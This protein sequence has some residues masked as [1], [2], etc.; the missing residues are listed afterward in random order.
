MAKTSSQKSSKRKP[1]DVINCAQI[2]DYME[3]VESGEVRA[4]ERQKKLCKHIRHVFATEELTIDYERIDNYGK[5]LRFFPFDRLF[6]WEWFVLT[7]FLCV[8]K[9]NGEP[10]WDELYCIVGRGAGKNGL[11][12]FMAFCLVAAANGIRH[13]NVNIVANSEEQAKTSFEDVRRVLNGAQK[14][15]KPKFDWNKTEIVCKST[16]SEIKY[17]TSGASSKDGGRP[18]LVVFD[19]VHEFTSWKLI[20]VLTTG[21]GKVDH[22]RTAIISSN[23][24]VRGGVF[25]TILESC[26][27]ILNGEE[28]DNGILP[29]VCTLDN[30][31]EVHDEANWEKANP[32]FRYLPER[33]KNRTRKEYRKWVK[34][35]AGGNAS[36]MTRRMGIPQ[37][38][39]EHEIATWENLTRCMRP[40][41]DLDGQPCVLGLDVSRKDD[42]FSAVLLF[43]DGNGGYC[44]KHH[45]W[46]CRHSRDWERINEKVRNLNDPDVLTIVE[47]VEISMSKVEDWIYEQQGRYEI[48]MTACDDYRYD[49]VKGTLNRLGYTADQGRDSTIKLIKPSNHMRIQPIVNSAFIT[50]SLAWGE[51]PIMRWFT[52]NA[53]LVPFQNGNYK[54]DKIEARSRKTD[55]FMALVAAFCIADAIPEYAPEEIPEVFTW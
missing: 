53:K 8:F 52:H 30:K 10:R 54:Y 17:L 40:L 22:G 47:E 42:I 27:S 1:K 14:Y 13:Y 36:F 28:D 37:G 50:G 39:I 41:P 38:D 24:D 34:N 31:E 48:V 3:L 35:P 18:G 32:S 51:S 7:L 46:L 15:F 11:I 16:E 20:E 55:G 6:P 9:P 29:F 5:L 25:D 21:L 12:A 4:C 43:K 45:H 23:G 33:M 44:A 2:T 49:V 19:E 26:D